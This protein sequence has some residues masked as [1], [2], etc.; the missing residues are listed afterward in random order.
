MSW[1]HLTL[2]TAFV[3]VRFICGI[4]FG[5]KYRQKSDREKNIPLIITAILIDSTELFK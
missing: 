5:K 3:A 4:I 1:Q 2:V